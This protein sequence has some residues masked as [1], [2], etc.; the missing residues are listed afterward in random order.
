MRWTRMA[1]PRKAKPDALAA[2]ISSN[3]RS[4]NAHQYASA[5]HLLIIIKATQGTNFTNPTHQVWTRDAH[6]AGLAVMHYH[7]CD[8]ASP[9]LEAQHFWATVKPLW[10]N[11]DRLAIDFEQPALGALGPRGPAYLAA[12]DH[13]LHK[14]SG[15]WAIG[16]TFA[17][18]LSP[19]LRV[20]SGKW[21]VAAFG[22]TWPARARRQLPNGTMWAWQF[23]DGLEGAQGPRGAAGIGQCDMSVLSPPIVQLL[24]KTLHR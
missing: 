14:H 12:L 15:Q 4:F 23:T 11:G 1:W 22:N 13:E 5:G 10:R 6:A 24:H 3:N 21:W 9:L 17:S 8:G 2:D 7:F 16:Y 18:A 20:Q 19:S